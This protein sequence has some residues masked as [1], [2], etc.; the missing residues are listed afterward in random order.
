MSDKVF[1]YSTLTSAQEY[2]TEAGP[3][4]IN[5]G[6]NV[7][8]KHLWTPK[9]VVTEV[10]EAQL[11][12]LQRHPVFAAHCK[13]GF[14]VVSLKKRDTDQIVRDME[15]ADKSAQETPETITKKPGRAK[16]KSDTEAA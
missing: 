1:V 10:T 11:D 5:G 6:A 16:P 15:G 7:S 2:G 8:N 3:I 12:A 13:N 9:G 4:R 14:V